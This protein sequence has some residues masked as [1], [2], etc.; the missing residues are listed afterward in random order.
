MDTGKINPSLA[1]ARE[2]AAA[3]APAAADAE[4]RDHIREQFK[5]VPSI[6]KP[7]VV[8]ISSVQAGS[9]DLSGTVFSALHISVKDQLDRPLE[10]AVIPI[11]VY[12]ALVECLEKLAT[13]FAGGYSISIQC[14][15]GKYSREMSDAL[16]DEQ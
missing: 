2:R 3:A 5:S 11:G 12:T 14:V 13:S 16:P 15:T 9:D 6:Y 1:A 8:D 10:S 4:L 7:L